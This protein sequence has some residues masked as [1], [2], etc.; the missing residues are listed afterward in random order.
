MQTPLTTVHLVFNA[1]LDPIWLWSWR[2]GLDEVLNTSN[3]IC[4]MLDRHRDITFTRGEGWL[5]EQ[6]RKVDPAL[7]KRILGHVK[8]GRWHPVGG[9]YIQP[10]C[11]L[12]SGFA[13]ER[14][15]ALGAERFKEYFGRVPRVAYN[16]DSFGHAATLPQ[17]IRAAGQRY[18]V[19]M[20]PQENEMELPARLFRWRGYADGPEVIT[21]RIPQCYCCSNPAGQENHLDEDFVRVCLTELPAGIRHTMCFLGI[22]DHGG[23][24]TEEMIEWCRAHRDSFPGARLVFSSPDQFFAA[25]QR[26]NAKLPLVVGELQMHAVGCYSIHRPVKTALRRAEHRLAQAEAILKGRQV[27]PEDRANL[28]TAWARASFHQ[29]HDTLCGTCVPS[30]YEEVHA[31]LGQALAIAENI[32]TYTLRQQVAKLPADPAQRIV[33]Y[34]A[35]ELPFDDYVENEPYFDWTRWS[36]EWRLLDE[37]NRVVPCQEMMPEAGGENQTRLVFPIAAA[38]GEMRILRVARAPR[39]APAPA[40]PVVVQDAAMSLAGGPALQFGGKPAE[41][42]RFHLAPAFPLPQLALYDDYS[43]TWSHHRDRYAHAAP[44]AAVLGAPEPF[45]RGPFMGSMVQDGRIGASPVKA[46]WRIYRGKPWVELILRVLWIEQRRI[47]KLEWQL[48]DPIVQRED[49][50]M[51]GSLVRP[52]NGREHPLR[53]WTSVRLKGK[54]GCAAAI[55]APEIFALDVEPQC[56]RMTLLRSGIMACED[57]HRPVRPRSVF[58]DRGEHW[59]RLRFWAGRHITTAA[60]DQTA[61]GIHRP[62]LAAATTKGMK[63]KALRGTYAPSVTVR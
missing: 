5:Y 44:E 59:F 62:L 58:S 11:N 55:I 40:K 51:G 56:I 60:L 32:A 21:F 20:R 3:Y 34:N 47:L 17:M 10:D 48:P 36:P 42:L 45:D 53:D 9:W 57:E 12:P 4:D 23:G 15:I 52:A 63:T 39:V 7:F 2:D 35:S 41:A 25:I 27:S 61:Y 28:E 54:P 26:D 13:M 31:E 8:A 46:E 6:I 22:G 19:M 43:D 29:F 49:G 16:V 30:A 18:Y 33:L 24:P 38:P 14:Q 37:K 1:H 50:I